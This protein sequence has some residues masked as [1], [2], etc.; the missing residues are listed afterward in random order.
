MPIAQAGTFHNGWTYAIDS[1]NDGFDEGLIGEDSPVEIY[2]L[3]TK[4][5]GDRL[6]FAFN[7]NLGLNGVPKRRAY[8]NRISYG[9]LF[10]NFS[11][12]DALNLATD[13]V[14]AIRFNASNDTPQRVGLYQNPSA[15]SLTQ[16]NLGFAKRDSYHAAVE[17]L[18]G[19]I[20]YGDVAADYFAND[21]SSPTTLYGGS[22][23]GG[24]EFTSDLAA[25]DLDFGH[26]GA[27]GEHTV[28]FSVDR[29]L[30]PHESFIAHLFIESGNEGIALSSG[31]RHDDPVQSKEVSEPSLG[32]ALSLISLLPLQ[33][34]TK[35]WGTQRS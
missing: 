29:N 16:A 5:E 13:D 26:F 25:L 6:Y 4:E 1:F 22:L 28:G 2:G 8:N 12:S 19:A 27:T 3:A 20:S 31:D 23:I 30:L 35:F 9:D 34:L 21:P 15:A 18:G 14:Y 24:I 11:D 10:L 7:S 17:N 33:K 32:L